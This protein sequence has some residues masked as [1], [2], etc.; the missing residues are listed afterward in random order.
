MKE[1]ADKY[2]I[3]VPAI[4]PKVRNILLEYEWKGNLREL[5]NILEHMIVM[6]GGKEITEDMVPYS[7]RDS[8]SKFARSYAQ[9]NDL[10]KN[11]SEY[12]K[13]IIEEVLENT[14]WNK[15]LAARMLNIPRTTL[16]YKI[17]IYDLKDNRLKKSNR[18]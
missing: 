13:H 17:Q 15:S 14:D 11:V 8:V 12:E 10:T 9:V 2:S 18:H 6:S 3:K 4:S 1:L 16:M 5:K 7:V